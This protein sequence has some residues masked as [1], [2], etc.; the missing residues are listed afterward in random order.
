LHTSSAFLSQRIARLSGRARS[1]DIIVTRDAVTAMMYA[2]SI[3][4][5]NLPWH[6]TTKRNGARSPLRRLVPS[7]RRSLVAS[8]PTP[9][10]RTVA[11]RPTEVP[12]EMALVGKATIESDLY[13]IEFAFE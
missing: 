7:P 11:F 9:L 10:S 5:T 8:E 12:G 1:L 6:E 4:P 2:R 13:Q 3:G